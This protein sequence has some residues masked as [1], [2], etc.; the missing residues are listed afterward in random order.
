MTPHHEPDGNA[1]AAA[2]L[3]FLAMC[4]AGALLVGMAVMR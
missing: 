4:A 2:V 1:I 3:A